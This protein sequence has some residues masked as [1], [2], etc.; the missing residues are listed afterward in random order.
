MNAERVSLHDWVFKSPVD[1]TTRRRRLPFSNILVLTGFNVLEGLGIDDPDK[2]KGRNYVF[3]ARGRDLKGAQFDFA[4]LSRVDFTGAHL[5]NA[6]LIEAQ[7]DRASFDHAQLRGAW[8]RSAQLQGASLDRA[9]LQGAV[10]DGAQL[11]GSYLLG[12]QFQGASLGGAQFQGA[13]LF[14]AQLQGADLFGAQLQGA[15]LV[16]SSLQGASLDYAQFQFASLDEANF[17]GASLT[18]A[19]LQGASLRKASLIAADLSDASLWRT[20]L[21]EISIVAVTLRDSPDQWLPVWRPEGEKAQPWDDSAYQGLRK[22]MESLPPNALRDPAL[23]RIRI[24]DCANTDTTLASCDRSP[25]LPPEADAWRKAV[26]HARAEYTGYA[27]ALALVLKV[28]VCSAPYAVDVLRGLL[29]ASRHGSLSRFE[30]T[31]PNAPK[32]VDFI[33]SKDCP[34]SASLTE[35]DKARLLQI[36]RDAIKEAG[37]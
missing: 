16:S 26:I 37:R 9:Q 20:N 8:L 28:L 5:E 27:Q 35:A 11:Q 23:N 12:A 25:P 21:D 19:N 17:D 2:A 7:L 32:M 30:A 6:S 36:K 33:M 22:V 14:G 15:M 3:R 10:L 4:T 18:Y 31:G 29:F 34:V 1:G 13:Y 24:L